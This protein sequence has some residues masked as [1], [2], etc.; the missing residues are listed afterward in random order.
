MPGWRDPGEVH[1]LLGLCQEAS[2]AHAPAVASFKSAIAKDPSRIESYVLLAELQQGWL[3]EEQEAIKTMDALLAANPKSHR[4]CLAR[5]DFE[6][7]RGDQIT[8]EKYLSA[9]AELAPD[10]PAVLLAVARWAEERGQ[11]DDAR[12]LVE[13]GLEKNPKSAELYT[14]LADVELRAGNRAAAAGAL[15]RG[16]AELPTDSNLQV[17]LI[18]LLIDEKQFAEAT[19]QTEALRDAPASLTSYL[20]GRLAI[21]KQQW[22]QAI[23]HL[24][25]ARAELGATSFWS[26]RV[27]ALLG[28]CYEQIGD[29]EQRLAAFRR[30]VHIEPH[31][32]AARFGLARHAWPRTGSMR[33][34]SSWRRPARRPT[35]RRRCGALSP[36]PNCRQP[37][38][39][40]PPPATGPCS[41]AR[42]TEPRSLT[43][44]IQRT[45]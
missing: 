33:L 42:W 28:A 39:S 22:A 4:A 43:P 24:E 26:S 9:A 41:S 40:C 38:A 12:K 25:K 29:T 36:E 6:R 45:F 16:L 1:F 35:R 15:R 3:G 19:S 2:G 17:L 44:T 11:L 31:W 5:S 20:K 37:C 21:E 30:A 7:R 34:F 32:S 10:E 18:D 13:R 23:A 27:H 8:A 14:A